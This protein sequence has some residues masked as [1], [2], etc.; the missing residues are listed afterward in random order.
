MGKEKKAEF[1]VLRWDFNTDRLEHYDVLPGFRAALK[2]R[3]AAW[4][5]YKASKRFAKDV[6]TGMISEDALKRY[7]KY[8]ENLGELTDFIRNESAYRYWGKCEHE[9]IVHGWPVEKDDYKLDVHE[10]LMMNLP[11]I[12][13]ILWDELVS[14]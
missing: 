4:K 13:K 5:K 12:A 1:Y 6:E 7:Y 10:Q 14:E 3:K 9:M 11:V 2:E 8:P